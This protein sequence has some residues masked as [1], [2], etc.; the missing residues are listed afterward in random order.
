MHRKRL[1][2]G[3]V[4]VALGAGLALPAGASADRAPLVGDGRQGQIEDQ[5]I[6]VLRDNAAPAA[7]GRTKSKA[8]NGGGKIERRYGTALT[9]FSAELPPA[10]LRQVREDPAVAF[11]EADAVVTANPTQTNATW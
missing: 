7:V 11:V 6:V 1:W 4:A 5:Y 9:G 2:Q 10:A 8:R 3:A